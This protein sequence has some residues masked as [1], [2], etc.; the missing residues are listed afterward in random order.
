MRFL[1]LGHGLQVLEESIA[2]A[3]VGKVR[4]GEVL[5]TLTV[6]GA[7]QMLQGKS[8]VQ[9]LSCVGSVSASKVTTT[10]TYYY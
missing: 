3:G 7:F 9:D 6:E 10:T 8:I 5:H 2:E 1:I 4:M